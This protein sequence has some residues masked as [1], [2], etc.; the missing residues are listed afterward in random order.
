MSASIKTV[1]KI[2][3]VLV[4]EV[5]LNKTDRII[6]RI[7]SETVGNASFTKTMQML[8]ERLPK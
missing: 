7:A 5:G 2:I 3:S 6:I 8:L 1:E 4:E